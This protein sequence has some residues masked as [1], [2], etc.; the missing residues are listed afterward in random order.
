MGHRI[1]PAETKR[2]SRGGPRLSDLP[3]CGPAFAGSSRHDLEKTAR[4]RAAASWRPSPPRSLVR[5]ATGLVT[6]E[7][8]F[9][10]ET[11]A[12]TKWRGCGAARRGERCFAPVPHGHWKTTTVIGTFRL[13]GTTAPMVLDG[14][15]RAAFPAYGEQVVQP[16]LRVISSSWIICPPT[17]LSACAPPLRGRS[18]TLHAAFSR[19]QS[20]RNGFLKTQHFKKLPPEPGML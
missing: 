15:N 3:K 11:G 16:C 13:S 18:R 14:T 1:S 17:R 5:S 12:S 10:D 2:A 19:R 4:K 7:P 6:R 20:H 8:V 9:I